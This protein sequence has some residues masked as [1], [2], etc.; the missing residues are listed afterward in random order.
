MTSLGSS[1][2]SFLL[3]HIVWISY[4]HKIFDAAYVYDVQQTMSVI[5]SARSCAINRAATHEQRIAD[6]D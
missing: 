1:G 3:G 2:S 5:F 4:S 6:L